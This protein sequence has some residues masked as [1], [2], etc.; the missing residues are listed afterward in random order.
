[1]WDSLSVMEEGALGW[2]CRKLSE[3]DFIL[4]ICSPGLHQTP[5]GHDGGEDE[6][7]DDED[8]PQEN[9]SSAMVALI[10]EE[11][12]RAKTTINDISRYITAVFEYSKQTDV[13]TVLGLATHYAL[14]TD[15]PL[16]FSHLHGVALQ[17][18]GTCLKVESISEDFI[19]HP[20]GE[21]LRK[22]IEEAKVGLNSE[23]QQPHPK[24]NIWTEDLRLPSQQRVEC[25]AIDSLK[26]WRAMA[27]P[28]ALNSYGAAQCQV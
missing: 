6:D 25:S 8:S 19:N 16:L 1:M 21:A 24:V 26:E 28:L 18:P 13:P 23:Q 4:V 7:D 3:S 12:C 14:T 11:L 5:Q 27:W 15:L 20:A 10:A 2:Y 17:Q 9:I 22:A